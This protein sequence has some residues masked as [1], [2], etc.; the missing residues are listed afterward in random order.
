MHSDIKWWSDLNN[1]FGVGLHW[2]L[3]LVYETTKFVWVTNINFF[4]NSFW[5]VFNYKNILLCFVAVMWGLFT[6][7]V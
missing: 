4:G 1:L 3:V 5:A 7:I 2:G 6:T